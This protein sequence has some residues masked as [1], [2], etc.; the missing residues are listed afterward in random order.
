MK[1]T[2]GFFSILFA[3]LAILFASLAILLAE[4]AI[5]EVLPLPLVLF[6]VLIGVDIGVDELIGDDVVFIFLFMLPLPLLAAG[7]PGQAAL[8]IPKAKTAERA[9]VF[10]I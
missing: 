10:F 8:M 1:I 2:Y 4:L 6:P 7:S 5:L 3:S 9:K